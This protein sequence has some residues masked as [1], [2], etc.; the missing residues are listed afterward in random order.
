MWCGFIVR[1]VLFFELAAPSAACTY[2]ESVYGGQERIIGRTMELGQLPGNLANWQFQVHPRGEKFAKSMKLGGL[3]PLAQWH[4]GKYGYASMDFDIPQLTVPI[5]G[6]NTSLE[7]VGYSPVDGINEHGLTISAN[8]FNM[9]GFQQT[10]MNSSEEHVWQWKF[11]QWVLSE[12]Q[13]IEELLKKLESTCVDNL[14]MPSSIDGFHWAITDMTGTSVVIEYIDGAMQYWE[15]KV[16]MLTNDPS[17]PWHLMNLNQ[18]PFV[19]PEWPAGNMPSPGGASARVEVITD[20]AGNVPNA[21]ISTKPGKKGGS[22]GFNLGGLPGDL[23]PSSRFVRTFF[24][25]QYANQVVPWK[26]E[27]EGVAGVKGLLNGAW[28][29]KGIMAGAGPPFDG[30][31]EMEYTPWT[32]VKVPKLGHVYYSTY[33]NPQWQFVDLNRLNFD[34]EHRPIQVE[35]PDELGLKD[36]TEEANKAKQTKP[37]KAA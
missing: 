11:A 22:H 37:G 29:T 36:L 20:E 21:Q 28:I 7:F 15:N 32:V 31:L 8:K 26:T 14:L 33:T 5:Y 4:E 34:I 3:K 35:V 16:G 30:V 19:S 27:H 2:V 23:S 13:T 17:Y 18:Y 10:C 6:V 1:V 25:K 12:F 9:A 24:L